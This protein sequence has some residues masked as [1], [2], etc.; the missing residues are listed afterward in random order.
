MSATLTALA[1]RTARG[2]QR[3]ERYVHR[4]LSP[5]A[6]RRG[7]AETRLFAR[8]ADIVGPACAELCCPSRISGAFGEAVLHIRAAPAAALELVHT[9]P[10][11]VER[12]NAYFGAPTVARLRIVQ[13]PLPAPPVREPPTL[14]LLGAAEAARLDAALAAIRDPVLRDALSG[15][16]RAVIGSTSAR[17]DDPAGET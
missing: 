8:W 4:L 15:L 16:G 9:E 13:A 10:L 1:A 17:G 5:A 11:V 6:R 7:F 2:P 14:R 3:A 12:I